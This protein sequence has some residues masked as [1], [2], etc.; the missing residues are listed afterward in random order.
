MRRGVAVA[1]AGR[2]IDVFYIY[3]KH[4]DCRLSLRYIH[5]IQKLS[6]VKGETA[7]RWR[8]FFRRNVRYL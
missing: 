5:H 2:P 3:K 6:V 1:I 8:I 4:R 7:S